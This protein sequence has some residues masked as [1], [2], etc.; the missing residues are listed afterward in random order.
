M[1]KRYLLVLLTYAIMQFSG[2]LGFPLFIAL[3]VSEDQVVGW[4]LFTSFSIALIIIMYLLRPEMKAR[5]LNT[6]RVSKVEAIGWSFFGVFLALFAQMIAALIE[7]KLF[8][9]DPGSENTKILVEIA[10]ATPIFI[11]VTSVLGPILEEIIFRQII[12]GEIYK[13]YNFIIAALISSIIFAAVHWDFSHLLIYT[14]MGFTF[15]YLYVKTNR[16]IV[17][18]VAHVSMNTLVVLVNVLYAD[19]IEEMEKQLNKMQAFIS[20]IIF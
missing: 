4:W 7:S 18:I 9:I 8:G 19:K 16:I 14:A 3:G 11:I 6:N 13:R 20:S 2:I 17:P 1:Y 15:A 12:F 5:N 10:K